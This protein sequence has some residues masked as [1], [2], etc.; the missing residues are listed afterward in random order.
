MKGIVYI[1]IIIILCLCTID[2]YAQQSPETLLRKYVAELN[3]WFKDPINLSIDDVIDIIS[4]KKRII[5]DG[6]VAKYNG[7]NNKATIPL[8]LQG[9]SH[10]FIQ[11]ITSNRLKGQSV[12]IICVKDMSNNSSKKLHAV[13]KY[14]G[15]IEITT[16]CD[17]Y[18]DNEKITKIESNNSISF[19]IKNKTKGVLFTLKIVEGGSFLMGKPNNDESDEIDEHPHNVKVNSFYIGETEVTQELWTAVMDAN[20]SVFQNDNSYDF[21][22]ENVSWDSTQIFINKLNALTNQK[23]RLPTETEWE[24]A[25]TGGTKSKGYKYS[26]SNRI[27][28]V[29][30]YGYFDKKDNKKTANKRQ[31]TSVKKFHPNELG[32]YDMSGNVYEWCQDW[33]AEDYHGGVSTTQISSSNT[34][35]VIRGGSWNQNQGHCRVINRFSAIPSY[36]SHD[37]GFRLALSVD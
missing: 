19:E 4:T 16:I 17:Y 2:L 9:Y 33:Y 8:S 22:I 23:F 36:Q 32:I 20:P 18:F 24:F 10:I 25:A 21:P 27:Y 30:W 3:T 11:E 13:L 15:A 14:S 12:E 34:E 29:A 35:R 26:G 1:I 28:N 7:N 37:V 31:T 6:I 5:N